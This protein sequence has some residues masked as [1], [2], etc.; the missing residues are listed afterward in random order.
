MQATSGMHCCPAYAKQGHQGVAHT[1]ERPQPASGRGL[2]HC[3]RWGHHFCLK[4]WLP[5]PP[6]SLNPTSRLSHS[7]SNLPKYKAVKTL[8]WPALVS[9]G[10]H[11]VG[12]HQAHCV[13]GQ[14]PGSTC[15]SGPLG[16]FWRAPA[17]ALGS[18]RGEQF[19]C[20][21]GTA[22]LALLPPCCHVWPRPTLHPGPHYPGPC[23]WLW[24]WTAVIV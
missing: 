10:A 16:A 5:K 9:Y 14:G 6:P 22:P 21:P 15:P 1:P 4:G 24:V 23:S 2:S 7:Q 3:P 12:A 20:S 18:S 17:S 13:S 19:G 11:P 8:L